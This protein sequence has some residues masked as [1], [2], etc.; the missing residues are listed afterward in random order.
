MNN[1]ANKIFNIMKNAGSNDSSSSLT[2]LT[3]KSITPLLFT[4]DD[5]ITLDENFYIISDMIDVTKLTVGDIVL[6]TTYNDGQSYFIQEGK[7][8]A[9][10]IYKNSGSSIEIVDNLT[11]TDSDK[12]LSANQGKLL[13]EK[14][15]TVS[16]K[17]TDNSNRIGPLET[18]TEIL[19]ST[20]SEIQSNKINKSGDTITGSIVNN[21]ATFNQGS[22]MSADGII[23][24]IVDNST[25]AHTLVKV[26]KSDGTSHLASLEIYDK[27][28][29]PRLRLFASSNYLEVR[30]NEI[31]SPHGICYN[32]IS[33]SNVDANTLNTC[34]TYYLGENCSNIPGAYCKL[35]VMGS[36]SSGD[37]VQMAIAVGSASRTW[38]RAKSSG[39]WKNWN[40]VP[41]SHYAGKVNLNEYK[42]PGVFGVDNATNAPTA[43]IAVLE[44]L[45]YSEDWIVQRFNIISHEQYAR[46]YE[47]C[48]HS[49][50]TWSS[51]Q[52]IF[53]SEKILYTNDSGSS[54]TITLSESAAHFSMMEIYA[55]NNDGKRGYT[56][57]F[58]PHNKDVTLDIATPSY[59]TYYGKVKGY[60][61]SGT[62]IT[63]S[64]SIRTMEYY[65]ANG[66][67]TNSSNS[68]SISIYKVIGY[69]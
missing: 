4:L 41:L 25:G 46:T 56:K 26:K 32:N 33:K 17:V 9:Q 43:D 55:M 61:I 42:N 14:I 60:T 50:T 8:T 52:Q 18:T 11:S 36:E 53:R 6:A 7:Q 54:G 66:T 29:D 45:K 51:W 13:N 57:V 34:G 2:M 15:S 1:A 44:V 62:S 23:T 49:G 38:I 35:L 5:R 64:M 24:Q 19:E 16:D 12:A 20:I 59:P 30:P 40:E 22:W 67:T 37:I 27:E 68:N 65:F 10:N 58:Y 63:L 28:D 31:F 21:K 3:V 48:W 47:R 69:R 39:T